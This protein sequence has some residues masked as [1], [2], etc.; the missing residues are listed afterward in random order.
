MKKVLK[1]S[2]IVMTMIG[3]SSCDLDE[4]GYSLGNIWV[5]FG[6]VESNEDGSDFLI[7]VDDGYAIIPVNQNKF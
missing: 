7:R 5:D 3:L 2:L 1:L 4:D 6:L